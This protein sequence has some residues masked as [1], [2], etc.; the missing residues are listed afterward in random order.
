MKT[1][2]RKP[3]EA[4]AEIAEQ[5]RENINQFL[6]AMDG[7]E[8]LLEKAVVDMKARLNEAKD[9]VAVAIAEEQRLKRAYQEAVDAAK[10]WGEKADDALQNRD[11]ALASEAQQRKRHHLKVADGY[12]HQIAAQTTVVTSLKTALHEFYQQFQSAAGHAE[13]LSHRQKQAETRAGLYKLI[14]TAESAISTALAQAEQKLKTAE[15]KAEIWE[16]RNRRD[17]ADMKKNADSSNLDQ[18][19]A[20]LKRDVL[21]DCR[22]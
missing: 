11:I 10:M 8:S 13:T 19:L 9:L 7:S 1:L 14:A 4:C 20:E 5:I 22:K 6:E 2:S 15:E 17:A 12:K 18:S 16:N 21:G 3:I